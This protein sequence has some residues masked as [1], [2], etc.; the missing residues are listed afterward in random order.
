MT[1]TPPPPASRI[2]VL[3]SLFGKQPGDGS[4]YRVLNASDNQLDF[5]EQE[6]RRYLPGTPPDRADPPPL[7]YYTFAPGPQIHPESM[8]SFSSLEPADV[9]DGA[10]RPTI[11]VRYFAAFFTVITGEAVPGRSPIGYASLAEAMASAA[12]PDAPEQWAELS[13]P[14]GDWSGRVADASR[15]SLEWLASGAAAL[16]AGRVVITGARSLPVVDRLACLDAIASLLPFGVRSSLSAATYAKSSLSH[17]I[18]LFFGDTPMDGAF[19]L[20][21]QS[22]PGGPTDQNARTYLELF[23]QGLE[24]VRVLGGQPLPHVVQLLAESTAPLDLDRP[25]DVIEEFKLSV[26]A[27]PQVLRRTK[28][29]PEDDNTRLGWIRR[30]L[31]GG[32]IGRQSAEDVKLGCWNLL[33]SDRE[34]PVRAA[35]LREL[36]PEC[37]DQNLDDIATG[38]RAVLAEPDGMSLAA[39]YGTQARTS[40]LLGELLKKIFSSIS[41]R[42]TPRLAAFAELIAQLGY[43]VEIRDLLRE[44]NRLSFALLRNR[45][46][47]GWASLKRYLDFLRPT[48]ETA[49][50]LVPL[51]TLVLGT[52]YQSPGDGLDRLLA[53]P[54]Y[55]DLLLGVAAQTDQPSGLTWMYAPLARIVVGGDQARRDKVSAWLGRLGPDQA[56]ARALRILCGAAPSY[57]AQ[58]VSALK[59]L[60]GGRSDA[61]TRLRYEIVKQLPSPGKALSLLGVSDDLD[62]E[63][64]YWLVKRPDRLDAWR[65]APP[66]FTQLAELRKSAP[67][68]VFHDA[69][70]AVIGYAAS[71]T[72]DFT[73]LWGILADARQSG[74]PP[75]RVAV[76]LIPLDQRAPSELTKFIAHDDGILQWLGEPITRGEM[77]PAAALRLREYIE[78]SSRKV[79]HKK[80]RARRKCR[81]VSWIRSRSTQQGMIDG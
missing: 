50:W 17:Q 19:E 78:H 63:V 38:L 80:A 35:E 4:D 57:S 59:P 18:R 81:L 48:P 79:S 66:D 2:S 72:T 20:P 43:P 21:W 6:I 9:R 69:Q 74:C 32:R 29:H 33:A 64:A 5:Y 28:R 70:L 45:A 36:S 75:R 58:D 53:M 25:A 42:D 76:E 41:P 26:L 47:D 24:E 44:D 14:P 11:R 27:V 49:D 51:S 62:R 3:W 34:T 40:G 67:M 13:V 65:A 22:A 30:L 15:P 46:E 71:A 61:A 56:H 16:L 37:T 68:E 39:D 7:P 54:G 23:W 55:L 1:G 73:Q 77:G 60:L 10:N 12:I 8:L 52:H 31:R